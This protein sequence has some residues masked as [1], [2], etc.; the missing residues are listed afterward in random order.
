MHANSID[1]V[2]LSQLISNPSPE[3]I[4]SEAGKIF[5]YHYPEKNFDEIYDSFII[6]KKLFEG[7]FPGYK[8]CNTKYHNFSH[9]MDILLA[10]ARLMDGYNIEND[11][12]PIQLA[13]NLLNAA[14]SHDTGYIQEEKDNKGTGAKHTATHVKRSMQFIERHHKDFKIAPDQI[15]SINNLILCTDLQFNLNSIEF[16]SNEEKLSGH[17]L[18]SS[19]IL[20]Q[21]SD[22]LYLEKL[23]L[24]FYEFKEAGIDGFNIEFDIINNTVGFY[25]FM[26]K[27]FSKTFLGVY[28]YAQSHF[29]KRFMIDRNLYIEAIEHNIEH[30]KIIINDGST[31]FRDKLRRKSLVANQFDINPRRKGLY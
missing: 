4:I 24:L 17:I 11:L 2:Q 10:T 22:R 12:L 16:S 7:R 13:S 27:R 23:L 8:A 6:I 9:T 30:L 1:S 28:K 14:L 15:L 20:S 19:D 25:E 29:R 18:G 5:C 21:M 26:K 31:A 3:A